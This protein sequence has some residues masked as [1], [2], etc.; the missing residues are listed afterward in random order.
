M[1][2]GET[3]GE[4]VGSTK[5]QAGEKGG[6]I[7]GRDLTK[8]VHKGTKRKRFTGEDPDGNE[9]PPKDSIHVH[10]RYMK[11]EEYLKVRRFLFLHHFSGKV[12]NL[13]KAVEEECHKLGVMVD[14]QSCDISR[15]QN[16]LED[17]PYKSHKRAAEEGIV[18]GYHSGFPCTTYTRLRWRPAE[19]MPGPVRDVHCPYGFQGMSQK[20]RQECDAGTVMMARS[21]DMAKMIKRAD[22]YVKVGGFATLENPPPSDH[23]LH[24]SAWHMPEM[25]EMIDRA[26][27]WKCAH[28]NTCAFESELELGTRHYKP[29]MIGGTLF[30]IEELNKNCPCQGRPHEPV[31]GKEKSSKSAAYPKDFCQAYGALAARHFMK[32]AQSE[33]LEGRLVGMG[34]RIS[35]LK[36]AA[37]RTMQEAEDIN[38]HAAELSKSE[39]YARGV[40]HHKKREAEESDTEQESVCWSRSSSQ[41][42]D[43]VEELK[44]NS[45]GASQS[46]RAAKRQKVEL[47]PNVN[48][49]G[50]RGKHGLLKEPKGKDAVPK[51]LVYLGGMRD[52]H[53]SV[54]KRPTLQTQGTKMWELWRKFA[55]SHPD[56]LKVAETYGT[57]GCA[58]DEEVVK[59]WRKE[60]CD[61]WEIEEPEAKVTDGEAY[62][63]PVHHEMVSAWVRASGD[64]DAVVADWLRDGTPLCIEK[65]IETTGVFP[66]SD[67]VDE[68]E[69]GDVRQLVVSDAVLERPETLTNYKSVEEELDEARTELS[70]YE[71]EGYL[72][73]LTIQEA[74]QQ[75]G[76]GT[77]SRLGLVL[78]VKE[79]GEKKRRIVIDLRRSGGNA[80]SRLPERLVLPRLVDA[81]NLLKE[82]KKRSACF[83]VGDNG[84]EFALVDIHDA[85]TVLPV[86]KEELRHTLA[87]STEP[88]EMLM[89][90]ALLFGYKVAPLLYSRFAALISRMLQAGI[91]LNRGG[92]QTYL[93]DALWILQGTLA[94]RTNT[95]AYVLNTLAAFGLGVS[96]KKGSRATSA[97]WIGVQ[98]NILDTT[99]LV[100]G[101]PERFLDELKG[102]LE[103]WDN[104]GYAPLKELRVVAGKS[105]WLGGVLPRARWT[106]SVFYA[107]LSQTLKEEETTSSSSTARNRRGL[108]AVKRLELARQWMIHFLSAAKLRPMRRIAIDTSDLASINITTDASPEALGGTLAINGRIV[109]AY[110][111]T[112]DKAQTDALK[113]EFMESG[114]QSVLEALAVLVA[115]RRWQEKLK[116]MSVTVTVQSDSVTALALAQRLSAKSSSPGLNFL[117]AELALCLEELGIEEL[118]TRHIPGKANVASDFLSRPSSWKSSPMPEQLTGIDICP[119]NGP[120]NSGFYRLPTPLAA[121][122]LWGVQGEA[123]GGT[124]MWDAVK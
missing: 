74:E 98:L 120:M 57:E 107:V 118:R 12:D 56:S 26:P 52:P 17:E 23:P 109:A 68:Q 87:P 8:D 54:M 81:V 5:P 105:A 59:A 4:A 85:F 67:E 69:G 28:F 117:G 2:G 116:G 111:S 115:L 114:S 70:R 49:K 1:C 73:R 102:M 88:G 101:I 32:I 124:A 16:L 55:R 103:K 15:G 77:V 121:P 18:D 41:E 90:R 43:N 122:T 53:K 22:R 119:D 71:K 30:G 46:S 47:K 37:A 82:V 7:A 48:W 61:L 38:S 33:F 25:V 34:K 50:G 97:T 83:P 123:A 35:H 9:E 13:S 44:G 6:V 66:P 96:L 29:Q 75:Y 95:L 86:A 14:T 78:K 80:K 64:P 76:G 39:A 20:Q 3:E 93:D 99:T 113:V 65:P 79:N 94:A 40:E 91:R 100:V 63:S 10:G 19:G 42:R 106:T 51:A 24:L 60:L 92:H 89:F 45:D 58:F 36:K 84:L 112:I 31:L 62:K 104:A 72:R 110:F 108:F 27:E 11:F 21:V